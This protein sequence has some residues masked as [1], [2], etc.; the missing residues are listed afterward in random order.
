MSHEAVT[1]A[2]DDAPML[3]T[4]KGKPDTT[5]RHV[6]QV[7]AEHANKQGANARPSLMRIQY[8]S[9]YDRRTVQR[10]LRRL[11]DARLIQPTGVVNG[12]T[13]YRLALATKRPAG[14]WAAL[15]KEENRQREVDAERQ[16]R[17][18]SRGRVT[19]A[20]AVTV[21]DAESVTPDDRHALSVR[22][23]RTQNPDVT[24]ATPPEPSVEHVSEPSSLSSH[25]SQEPTVP[26]VSV[27]RETVASTDKPTTAQRIVRAAGL[28]TA[29]EETAFIAWVRVKHAPAAPAFWRKVE[30]EGD[31]PELVEAWRASQPMR[32][33][34][35]LIP[36]WCGHCNRG[37]QPASIA[38][39][40]TETTDGRIEPCRACHPKRR[41]AA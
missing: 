20:N 26:P 14:D 29:N 35:S 6:L 39:R 13:V 17:Y 25:A 2:M 12:C 23:S 38:E 32:P 7:L 41:T 10:A 24:D 18:R 9:G 4:D 22:T 27:E 30:A 40:L 36:D 37:N 33:T 11:E 1:W 5:A 28:L 19:D 15:E 16:R 21:T 34:L 31:L 8:R 3:L